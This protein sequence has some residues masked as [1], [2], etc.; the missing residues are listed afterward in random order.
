MIFTLIIRLILLIEDDDKSDDN[1]MKV[2]MVRNISTELI[3]L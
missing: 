2:S 3:N 1:T